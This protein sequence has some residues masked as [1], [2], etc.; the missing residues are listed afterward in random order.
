LS[1]FYGCCNLCGGF[2]IRWS[3]DVFGNRCVRCLSTQIHRAMGLAI[4]AIDLPGNARAYELSSR[5]ALFRHLRRRF[6]DFHFSEYFD[7]VPPGGTWNEVPCQDVQNL[8]HPN[9]TFDLVTS[10]EVFE[11]VPDDAKG[12]SEIRRVLKPGGWLVFTVPLTRNPVTVERA[13]RN[14]DGRVEHMLPPE[15]HSDRL[16]GRGKILA[17]RNYGRDIVDRLRDAGLV[18]EIL[19]MAS[20]RF[21]VSPLDVLTGRKAGET[22]SDS[23]FSG[24]ESGYY[25]STRPEL[26]DHLR[27]EI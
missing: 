6:R 21:M 1:R 14:A 8:R 2:V 13:R 19:T 11:H 5:G 10:T 23:T 12:F 24:R 26:H 22:G 15:Y 7:D 4:D 16:R 9:G 3:S 25:H 27:P 18:P 17:Y 20:A